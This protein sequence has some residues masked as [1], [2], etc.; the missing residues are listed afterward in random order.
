MTHLEFLRDSATAR[1][2]E[3]ASIA[4]GAPLSIHYV[5]RNQEGPRVCG[6]GVCAACAAVSKSPEGTRACR[7]SRTTAS[8]MAIQ[9]QRPIS[10]LC[11]LGFACVAMAPFA[12][13]GYVVTLGPYCPME[14]QR[15]LEEDV[16]AGYSALIGETTAEVPF[17][18][19][20]IHRAPAASVPAIA[21]WL[22][23]ALGAQWEAQRAVA[24]EE[25]AATELSQEA[26]TGSLSRNSSEVDD[27]VL[28]VAREGAAALG[29][30][31][32][33][34]ARS[35]FQGHLEELARVGGRRI[36]VRR[37]RMLALTAATLEALA[38]SGLPI[39][40]GW[41]GF[42]VFA[43]KSEQLK[44]DSDLL[45]GAIGVFSFLRKKSV[46]EKRNEG[47]PHY[48]E[49]YALVNTGLVEGITLEAVAKKLGESPTNISHRLRRKFGMSYSEY[50]ARIRVD[51]AKQLFRRTK[52]STTEVAQRVG[53]ADQSNFAKLFKKI[54]GITPTAYRKKYGKGL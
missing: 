10:Y 52:L 46:R 51:R 24:S 22:Q 16:Q 11:H 30:D 17:T 1:L 25:A 43:Q 18:L 12:D 26:V 9:Q 2:L 15:S 23:E 8:S 50:V 21:A 5:K 32:P 42:G 3:R 7:L 14:E 34:Q 48:P 28:T 35:L 19:E 39:E 49:L 44:S 36:E 27:R 20:D 47:L 31:N 41:A 54:E 38:R 40:S 45:E 13:E 37:A 53:I 33:A 6:R 4:A 29:A